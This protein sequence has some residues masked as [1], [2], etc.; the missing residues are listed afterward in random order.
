MSQL[1]QLHATNVI[2][3]NSSM[4]IIFNDKFLQSLYFYHVFK[5]QHYMTYNEITKLILFHHTIVGFPTNFCM[6]S[7]FHTDTSSKVYLHDLTMPSCRKEC[8]SKIVKQL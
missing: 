3:K 6:Y 5:L 2:N 8:T 4:I 7:F 1:N